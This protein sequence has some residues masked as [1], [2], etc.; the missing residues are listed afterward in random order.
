MH[1]EA[2]NETGQ[3]GHALEPL[4]QVRRR[5]GVPVL[6]NMTQAQLR[7]A[8]LMERMWEL[9]FENWRWYD[10]KRTGK[11]VERARLW[12][13]RAAA[14]IKESNNLYPIPLNEINTNDAIGP[15]DQ[16]P[17]YF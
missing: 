2:L 12:N 3:P 9:A 17:G 5:A 16:N 6:E 8:I 10:L 15:D 1:A 14:N 7:D 11:L 4:N 13:P